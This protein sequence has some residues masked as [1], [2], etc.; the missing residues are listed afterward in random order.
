MAALFQFVALTPSKS[1]Y[2]FNLISMKRNISL[3]PSSLAIYSHETKQNI[4][5]GVTL[6]NFIMLNTAFLVVEKQ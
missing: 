5:E 1:L 2:N 3:F 4:L 6:F